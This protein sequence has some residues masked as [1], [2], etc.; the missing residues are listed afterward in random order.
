[1]I[2]LKNWYQV[3]RPREDLRR[4]IPLD[5]AEFAIHLDQVVDGRA[6]LDY[7]D[8][9]RFFSRTYFTRAYQQLLI[10]VL[11]RLA[12]N[13]VGT[14]P[15][16]NLIAQFGGGKTHFLTLL[17]HL[18]KTPDRLREYPEVKELLR[19]SNLN[20]IPKARVAVFIGNQFDFVV[21]RGDK[22]KPRRKTPWGD[23][24]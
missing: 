13:V 16:I 12:G 17:Y 18:L 22:G 8:P 1:M 14:S 6:P 2:N 20:S 7:L 19:E 3:A 24:A 9:E 10:E 4:G 5:A 21:G 15:G 11:K 23:L